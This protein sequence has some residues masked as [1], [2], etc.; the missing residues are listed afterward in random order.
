MMDDNKTAADDDWF[1]DLDNRACT[2]KKKIHSWL[3]GSEAESH[4]RALQE[5]ANQDEASNQEA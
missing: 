2:F 1:D 4:Q 5:E 3:K